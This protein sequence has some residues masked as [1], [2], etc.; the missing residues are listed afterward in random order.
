MYESLETCPD[1]LLLF[2]HH[3][4]Y[5]YKLHNGKTVI[6]YIY[7]V[8]Y[9]GAEEAA[10]YVRDW[11][12]LHGHIDDDRYEAV[13]KQLEYQAGAAQLWRD[14]ITSWFWKTSGIPDTQGRVG[15]Y[16][17]RQEAEFMTLDGYTEVSANPW[18]SASGGKGVECKAAKCSASFK[19]SGSAGWHTLNVRYFDM[20]MGVAHFKLFV[21]NQQVAEWAAD[22]H[23]PARKLDGAAST[24][25]LVKGI[26]LRPGDEIRV[27][28]VPDNTDHAALDYIEIVP[29]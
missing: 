20:P 17:A 10:A 25:I 7:D 27:E 4:P 3:V 24:R 12:P 11:K 9:Q 23:F 2:M 1:D 28:G 19:Y 5:T 16:P 22:D 26:A 29:D 18:E 15:H 13:L 6:Q 21:A 14:A 8:H